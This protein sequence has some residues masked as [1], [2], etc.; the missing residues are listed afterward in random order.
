MAR[1][2]HRQTVSKRAN[3]CDQHWATVQPKSIQPNCELQNTKITKS[4]RQ[5]IEYILS[6]AFSVR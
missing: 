5:I 6:I 2:K 3:E 4:P 1:N